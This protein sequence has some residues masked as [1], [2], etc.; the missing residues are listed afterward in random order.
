M[1]YLF[2]I[3]AG[4]KHEIFVECQIFSIYSTTVKTTWP[5][6]NR[7]FRSSTLVDI[8]QIQLFGTRQI[9]YVCSHLKQE[10]N[11]SSYLLT[12]LSHYPILIQSYIDYDLCPMIKHIY[13]GRCLGVQ[14]P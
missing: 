1:A 14:T 13:N 2:I 5:S 7:N 11:N 3:Y 8:R 6:A 9:P 4:S 12:L 10:N